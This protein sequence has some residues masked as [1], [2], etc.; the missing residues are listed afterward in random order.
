MI[1]NSNIKL[2]DTLLLH[3]TGRGI[4]HHNLYN[5]DE[6]YKLYIEKV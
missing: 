2:D 6:C 5:E 1:D 3:T 4:V